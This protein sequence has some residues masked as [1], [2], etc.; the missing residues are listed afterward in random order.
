[1]I[2]AVTGHRPQRLKGQQE[3]IKEWATK[4]LI[5]FNPSA[6]YDGMASGVDQIVAVAA[7]NLDIPIVCCYPF[8]KNNFH[9]IQEWIMENNQVIFISPAYSKQSYIIRDKYMVDHADI[10][11]CVW[12]GIAAGGT[13][14]TYK[15][16]LSKKI[17][18]IEYQGLKK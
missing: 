18:I 3:M 5:K 14:Q 1:M 17:P 12:D 11:L 10:L 2:L 8:P 9:P 4:Q 15:Y 6:V 7:K 13:Y 16:A